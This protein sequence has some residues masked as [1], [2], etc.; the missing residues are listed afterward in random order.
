MCNNSLHKI[1]IN[2]NTRTLIQG[3]HENDKVLYFNWLF[4]SGESIEVDQFARPNYLVTTTESNPPRA[5]SSQSS[6][7]V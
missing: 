2:N 1:I 3:Y 4:S 6:L 5:T 7:C